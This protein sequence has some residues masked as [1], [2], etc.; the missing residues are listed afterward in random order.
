MQFAQ[1]PENGTGAYNA[2]MSMVLRINPQSAPPAYFT[3]S[4]D[5]TLPAGT[6]NATIV[7]TQIPELVVNDEEDEDEEE[8]ETYKDKFER[9]ILLMEELKLIKEFEDRPPAP[10]LN[11]ELR[12]KLQQ[13]SSYLDEGVDRDFV[14]RR[15]KRQEETPLQNTRRF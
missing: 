11:D 7:I 2:S 3:F 9:L 6:T 12:K 15:L 1:S 14:E 13:R 8:E 10:I 5:G 4:S